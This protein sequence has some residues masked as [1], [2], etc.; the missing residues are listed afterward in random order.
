MTN[1]ITL[2]MK[3]NVTYLGDLVTYHTSVPTAANT[4]K[5][6]LNNFNFF[7]DELKN[8]PSSMLTYANGE[9]ILSI[10]H[11]FNMFDHIFLWMGWLLLSDLILIT[12]FLS[13]WIFVIRSFY[14]VSKIVSAV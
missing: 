10:R 9:R 11:G 3:Q 7:T 8:V 12:I 6:Y 4:M 13:Y 14:I 5:K 1:D 2:F